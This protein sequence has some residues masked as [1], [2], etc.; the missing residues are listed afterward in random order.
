MVT[1]IAQT[2]HVDIETG[3][4]IEG[5]TIAQGSDAKQLV[6]ATMTPRRK[7]T[8]AAKLW[9]SLARGYEGYR[10]G[11]LRIWQPD[12][13]LLPH[14]WICD[15]TSPETGEI[16]TYFVWTGAAQWDVAHGCECRGYRQYSY[17]KHYALALAINGWLPDPDDPA[18]ITPAPAA[19]PVPPS[20]RK[21]AR[22]R[23]A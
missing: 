13:D 21:A 3:E 20:M 6:T 8:L 1:V 22:N 15:S 10:D 2:R 23:A 19:L 11:F 7:M 12:A 17:C 18:P 16:S 4:I 5:A 14:M 9:E